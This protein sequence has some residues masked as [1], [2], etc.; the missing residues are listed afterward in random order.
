MHINL[1]LLYRVHVFLFVVNEC[2]LVY[3]AVYS[4]I[5]QDYSGTTCNQHMTGN[6]TI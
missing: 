5:F 2:K 1:L 3:A 4:M 6:L